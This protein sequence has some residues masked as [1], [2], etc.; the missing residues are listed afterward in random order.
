MKVIKYQ[1]HGTVEIIQQ[2]NHRK[3]DRG[4]AE[5]LNKVANLNLVYDEPEEEGEVD[6]CQAMEDYT[7]KM[8]VISAINALKLAGPS[9]LN[10]DE[11]DTLIFHFSDFTFPTPLKP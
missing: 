10:V 4:T 11:P 3:I 1:Q 9:A 2:T 7:K 5:F 6:M 8:K